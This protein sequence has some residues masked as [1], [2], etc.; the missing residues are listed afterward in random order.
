M[1]R[2]INAANIHA[3]QD[4]YATPVFDT[5][6]D[7]GVLPPTSSPSC[8]KC[9]MFMIIIVVL[10]VIL[11]GVGVFWYMKKKQTSPHLISA[12][13]PVNNPFLQPP[14]NSSGTMAAAPSSF[15]PTS[16]PNPNFLS[17]IDFPPASAP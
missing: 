13:T 16:K 11:V 1:P 4:P 9:K 14:V 15:Y 7:S 3:E 10:V 17:T 8:R 5:N 2:V 12:Q 6:S